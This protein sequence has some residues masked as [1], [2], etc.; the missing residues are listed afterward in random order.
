VEQDVLAEEFESRR[1]ALPNC[2]RFDETA[3]HD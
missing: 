2:D 1:E 3:A